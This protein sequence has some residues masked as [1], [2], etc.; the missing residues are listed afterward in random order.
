M[1][2]ERVLAEAMF[3]APMHYV[4][5]TEKAVRGEEKLGY[6]GKDGRFEVER[7]IRDEDGIQDGVPGDDP[8]GIARQVYSTGNYREAGES[9]A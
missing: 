5:V 8:S 1:E 9:G 3:D 7:R 6:W 4:L 2:V